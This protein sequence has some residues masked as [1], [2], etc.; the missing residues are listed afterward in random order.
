ME[1]G[2][3]PAGVLAGEG[4]AADAV[5]AADCFF[6]VPGHPNLSVGGVSGF[7]EALEA[8]LAA[9]VEAFMGGVSSPADPI[10]RDPLSGPDGRAFRSGCGGAPDRGVRWRGGLRGRVGDLTGVGYS[11]RLPLFEQAGDIFQPQPGAA[12]GPG[13][14][15]FQPPFKTA[16]YPPPP[17]KHP[18]S[19]SLTSY[20]PQART[21]PGYSA[22]L[23]STQ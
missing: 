3:E 12:A 2:G 6:G 23:N 8:D 16:K 7:E 9:V 13:P 11:G 18:L 22:Q 1:V 14:R 15:R 4:G 20:R 10:Q 19:T 21:P 17:K 5:D